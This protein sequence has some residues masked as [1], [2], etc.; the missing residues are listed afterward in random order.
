MGPERPRSANGSPVAAMSGV[1]P[2]RARAYFK[3]RAFGAE[4]VPHEEP[5]DQGAPE[6][7]AGVS[8]ETRAPRS[9]TL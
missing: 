3:E 9:D 2:P 8:Y 5:F 4:K 6:V 1:K 7:P